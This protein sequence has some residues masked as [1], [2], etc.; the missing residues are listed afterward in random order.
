MAKRHHFTPLLHQ[1]QTNIVSTHAATHQYHHTLPSHRAAPLLSIRAAQISVVTVSCKAKNGAVRIRA[2]LSVTR[3]P[4]LT[5]TPPGGQPPRM[6]MC[7]G[8]HAVQQK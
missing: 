2:V 1:Q 3:R 5:R 7:D 4:P 8:R 6:K